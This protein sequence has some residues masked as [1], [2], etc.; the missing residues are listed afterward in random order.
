MINKYL[1]NKI[2]SLNSDQKN[3]FDEMQK[4]NLLQICIPT[5]AG[6]G[7]LMI[8]D[9]L[10]QVVSKKSK[11]FVISSH[12]LMLNTQHLNDIF[13]TMSP[14]IG[15]VGFIFVGSSKY[16]TSKFQN[17]IDFNTQLLKKGISYNEIVSSTNRKTEIEEIVKNHHNSGRK[18]IILTTYHSLH[19]LKGLEI[20]T[21]YNDE[22]HTLA[23]ESETAQ[24]R[25]NFNTIKY[26]RCFF[27]TATPKD[28]VE[29]TETFLMNNEEAFGKRIG[30]NFRQCV[31]NGY[32]VKPVIHIAMP[33]E[34]NNS[35]ELVVLKFVP[36]LLEMN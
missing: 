4:D 23:S 22:A 16:D 15:D 13:D 21:I 3:L 25:D 1:K 36:V 18:V 11:T 10:N 30:L 34:Y 19:T 8:I 29:D 9:L 31:E 12:R 27:L 7:Y 33:E 14:I 24:F 17:N 20:D 6:K 2:S 26:K 32:I 35:Y 28:C 5:G